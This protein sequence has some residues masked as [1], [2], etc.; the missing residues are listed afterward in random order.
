MSKDSVGQTYCYLNKL[1]K[2]KSVKDFDN[3]RELVKPL[4]TLSLFEDSLRLVLVDSLQLADN[5]VEILFSQNNYHINRIL[6]C[7]W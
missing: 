4:E 2:G 7:H 3:A 6:K 1:I 5:V